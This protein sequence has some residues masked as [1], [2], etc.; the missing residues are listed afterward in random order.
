MSND[1][2]KTSRLFLADLVIVSLF[3]PY[4]ITMAIVPWPERYSTLTN[5]TL[6]TFYGMVWM[7]T[8]LCFRALARKHGWIG[9]PKKP[10]SS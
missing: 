1:Q 10:I 9:F 2:S 6:I 8:L 5:A 3:L 4:P 7:G